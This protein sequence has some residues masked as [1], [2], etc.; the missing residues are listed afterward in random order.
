[1]W[2]YFKDMLK[3]LTFLVNVIV[4]IVGAQMTLVKR[5]LMIFGRV[6]E[7]S[8]DHTLPIVKVIKKAYQ[9]FKLVMTLIHTYDLY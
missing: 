1:M 9:L 4:K 6:L 8:I 3:C 5:L 2:G 7:F